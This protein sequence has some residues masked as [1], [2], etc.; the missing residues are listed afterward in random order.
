MWEL[1]TGRTAFAGSHFGE[2]FERVVLHGERPPPPAGPL[3]PPPG[4]AA[5][6][7]ECW[8]AASSL[9]E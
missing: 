7:E 2:V 9:A 6:M 3:A 4:Y 8:R 1:W 5:L